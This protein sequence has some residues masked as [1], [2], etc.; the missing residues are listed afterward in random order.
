MF[1]LPTLP[2]RLAGLLWSAATL[3][4]PL[5]AAG[6]SVARLVP[7]GRHLLAGTRLQCDDKAVRPAAL[8]P[9]LAQ[10]PNARWFSTMKVSL[11]VYA[12]AGRD[13]TRWV[14]RTLR[15]MGEAPVLADTALTRRSEENL[16]AALHD[17]GYLHADVRAIART[18]GH[19]L[20]L[21][22]QLLPGRRYYIGS[23]CR[24][25]PDTLIERLLSLP[26]TGRRRQATKPLTA[27]EPF[28]V[29]DLNAERR[30]ITDLLRN[31]GYYRF[32]KDYIYFD[33]DTTGSDSVHLVMHIRP[34]RASSAAEPTSHPRYHIRHVQ[35]PP[36]PEGTGLRQSVRQRNTALREGALF[37]EADVKRTYANFARLGA[38]RYAGVHFDEVAPDSLDATVQ[39]NM[40]RRRAISLQPEATNT[41]GN[42]G[43]AATLTYENRNLF[44]G[45]ETFTVKLRAAYEAITGLEGYA[46]KNYVEYG[47][48]AALHIPRLIGPL[49]WWR[50][51]R[52]REGTTSALAFNFGSQNRPEFR[53]TVFSLGWRHTWPLR[54]GG[55][56]RL[57]LPDINYVYMP[58]ISETFKADYLDNASSRNAILRY[59]YE[60]LFIMRAAFSM[61]I[62]RPGHVVRLGLE[63][64]GNLLE[65]LA[66]A[67][68]TKRN[69]QGQRTLFNIAYAQYVKF[70]FDYSRLIHF[71]EHNTLALHAALGVAVPYGNSHLLPFEKRYFS[72]GAN[73]VR[74]WGVRELGPGSFRRSDG[75]IDFINQTGD[76]KLDLSAEYR[77]FLFWKLDGAFFIDAG[78]IWILRDNPD[79]KGGLF[80]FNSFYKQIAMS[81]G[82]GLRLNFSYFILR[83][84]AA[85][86][87]IDPAGEGKYQF[88]IAHPNWGRD[89]Q[90][91]FAVG[92]PF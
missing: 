65:G 45:S 16:R 34:Y 51:Q 24:E 47:A 17:M 32:H 36:A 46:N 31:N 91:H 28:A 66:A 18:K 44:R 72:G 20:H 68:G 10:H 5:L 58:W 14:N 29:A 59:N 4:L 27:G 63:T 19:K 23:L 89:F 2:K 50:K 57:D 13:S 26:Q 8:E 7:E 52:E 49:A 88:P 37:R 39:V 41:A 30:R 9:Y 62:E 56:C 61:R 40:S 55:T 83:L 42:F 92:M 15:K 85:M 77:S 84:D 70:D 35:Q 21:T 33:A 12:L 54:R 81:Y 80:R 90:F 69:A 71:D 76:L 38:V 73:S 60:D 87:A 43:A 3:L 53:R 79:Q 86:K 25:C 48:E 64:A 74:G 22:Y 78:N 6:C 1:R 67:A 82:L 11:G 75:R